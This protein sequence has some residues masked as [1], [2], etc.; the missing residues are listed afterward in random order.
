M[1]AMVAPY[2]CVQMSTSQ[3]DAVDIDAVSRQIK[4]YPDCHSGAVSTGFLWVGLR[5][6]DY[7]RGLPLSMFVMAVIDGKGVGPV[8]AQAGWIEMN[9]HLEWKWIQRCNM[10]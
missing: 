4:K 5:H 8:V 1:Y 2:V 3:Q 9:P 6:N 10:M 7:R